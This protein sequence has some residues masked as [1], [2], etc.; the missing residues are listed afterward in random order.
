MRIIAI[1]VLLFS[2]FVIYETLSQTPAFS[3]K[4]RADTVTGTWRTQAS[5]SM[6]N[7]GAYDFQ[8]GYGYLLADV[9]LPNPSN[10]IELAAQGDRSRFALEALQTAVES[11]PGNAH[12]WLHLGWA[13]ARLG[14]LDQ[15]RKNLGVSWKLAP[16]NVTLAEL[17]LN[18]SGIIF[19]PLYEAPKATQFEEEAMNA[20]QAAIKKFRPKQSGGNRI[21]LEE[22]LESRVSDDTN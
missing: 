9:I 7:K 6:Y 8:R 22:I 13:N 14:D 20:D 17:R 2:G 12:I 19:D 16:N 11:D 4:L 15:A 1:L 10:N 5:G 18:L 3:A 21:S